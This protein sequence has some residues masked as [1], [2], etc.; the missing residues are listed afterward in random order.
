MR[1]SSARFSTLKCRARMERVRL[2]WE[3]GQ[4][5]KYVHEI[6]RFTRRLDAI[7]AAFLRI[8]L[9]HLQH[10]IEARRQVANWHRA[11][12]QTCRGSGCPLS[13][14][15]CATSSIYS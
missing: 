13:H 5:H 11:P 8:K 6:K 4:S 12:S 10:W 9:R 1:L 2:F 15:T 3:H 14:P 7:H